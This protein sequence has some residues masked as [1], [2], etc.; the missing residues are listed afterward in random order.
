MATLQAQQI[1]ALATQIAKCPGYVVQAGQFLNTALQ[2]FCQNYDLDAALGTFMF[3]FIP[4][5]T[6]V[7]TS[8]LS[9]AAGP[10]LLPDDY[11]RT[12]SKDGKD[13]FFYT[14]NGVPYPLI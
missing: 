7:S 3:S 12:Q 14:I 11:L 1:C 6:A 10:Y 2:D 8:L 13:E 4:A 5:S 9:P